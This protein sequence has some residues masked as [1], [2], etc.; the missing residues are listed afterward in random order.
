MSSNKVIV[1]VGPTASGKSDLAVKIAKKYKGEVISADSRQV[2]KGLNIGSGKITKKEMQ[3]VPH[4]LLDV[5]SPKT[6]FTA[7]KY[8]KLARKVV[9]NILK[10]GKVPVIV[11]GTGFYIDTLLYD[12][13]LP[14]VEPN[15]KLR[16]KLEN[17]TTAELFDLLEKKD[18]ER[19]KHIDPH[20][21]RR[22]IRAL[23]IVEKLGTVPK[24]EERKSRYEAIKIGILKTSEELRKRIHDRLLS[25][26]RQGMVR[27]VKRLHREGVSWKRME[28]LGLEYR[29]VSRYV[30]GLIIKE[31][32]LTTLEQEI[33]QYAKRQM[34]WFKKDKEIVWIAKSAEA[35]KLLS[36][37]KV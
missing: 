35:I 31:E 7:A 4:Y 15:H 10:H 3:G 20:N 29:Y 25:R 6:V 34:T 8:Q 1:I 24:L 12:T 13:S 23:E 28:D 14:E 18:P 19:A 33:F 5:A 21:P 32:M 16:A 9:N 17:K 2:Y 22:L 30:R 11:G 27:E 36:K 37:Q 26:M